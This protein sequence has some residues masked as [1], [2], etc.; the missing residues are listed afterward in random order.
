MR[1]STLNGTPARTRTLING[2]GDRCATFT[3]P[4]YEEGLDVLHYIV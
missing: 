3:P 4:R 2:F 1:L